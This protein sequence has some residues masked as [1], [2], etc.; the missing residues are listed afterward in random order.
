MRSHR[1]VPLVPLSAGFALI[2][3]RACAGYGLYGQKRHGT[4]LPALLPNPFDIA[5][6]Q[7]AGAHTGAGV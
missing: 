1:I 5:R 3:P 6:Y 7:P 2:A 4:A